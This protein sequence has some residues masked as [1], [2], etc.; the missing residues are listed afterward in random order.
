MDIK[1]MKYVNVRTEYVKKPNTSED[2]GTYVIHIKV[3]PEF[4]EILNKFVVGSDKVTCRVDATEKRPLL[5]RDIAR[6]VQNTH[7]E[8]MFCDKDEFV[9]NAEN[10]DYAESYITNLKRQIEEIVVCDAKIKNLLS[11]KDICS[12]PTETAKKNETTTSD[13][14]YPSPEHYDDGYDESED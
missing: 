13:E 14:S 4:K 8:L 11:V 6:I 1:Q 2:V 5:M 10:T 12:L 7:A 9:I 3:Y